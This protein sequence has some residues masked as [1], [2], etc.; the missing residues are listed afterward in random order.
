MPDQLINSHSPLLAL[1]AEILLLIFD[2][3]FDAQQP[4]Y[5]VGTTDAFYNYSEA[6]STLYAL[7][8]T[9]RSLRPIAK[10]VLNTKC[11][12]ESRKPIAAFTEGTGSEPGRSIRRKATHIEVLRDAKLF[13]R[14]DYPWRSQERTNGFCK[15]YAPE[16]LSIPFWTLLGRPQSAYT[17]EEDWQYPRMRDV[18]PPRLQE[19]LLYTLPMMTSRQYNDGYLRLFSS[20]LP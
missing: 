13:P 18:L 5:R 17:G 10:E 7:E 3:F 14:D 6:Y 1:P 4:Q 15:L 11:V 2:H 12:W 19:L 20:A 9:C 16:R 8:C